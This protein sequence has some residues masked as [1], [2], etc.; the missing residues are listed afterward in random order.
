[1]A[2][3]GQAA[4]SHECEQASVT[5]G[6]SAALPHDPKTDLTAP[7]TATAYGDESHL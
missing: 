2:A 7:R 6:A 3:T 1:M 4:N 5:A